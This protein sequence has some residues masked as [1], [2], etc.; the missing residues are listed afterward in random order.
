[1]KIYFKIAPLLSLL[2]V[3]S[4]AE[5]QFLSNPSFEGAPGIGVCPVTWLPAG[6]Y[7]SPDTEPL[8]CD[9]SLAP[10]DGNSYLTLVTRGPSAQYANTTES[11]VSQLYTPLL[12]NTCYT[13]TFDIASRDDVGFFSWERGFTSYDSPTKL[14]MYA[15]DIAQDKGEIIYESGT[16]S[17]PGWNTQSFTYKPGKAINTITFEANYAGTPGNGNVSI[18]NIHITK[19]TVVEKLILDTIVN[20]T[21]FPISLTAEEGSDYQWTP[22]DGLS[23]TQCRSP[24]VTDTLSIKYFCSFNNAQGCASRNVVIIHVSNDTTSTPPFKSEEDLFIPNVFTPNNDGINDIFVIVG[25]K[26]YSAL[27]VFDSSGKTVYKNENYENN[28]DGR[29]MQGNLLP[30]GTYWYVLQMP[31]FKKTYKGYVYLKRLN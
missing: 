28:W 13:I 24:L 27:I 1:M 16:I 8:D 12:A 22:P 25:L 15:S 5:G 3:F 31:G 10:S 23:C 20:V 26:P 2:A 4:N 9:N 11:T 6:S 7:S 18:D 14:I 17:N 30:E 21:D 19:N 29:D